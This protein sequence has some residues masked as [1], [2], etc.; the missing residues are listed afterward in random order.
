MEGNNNNNN[1]NNNKGKDKKIRFKYFR[2][3]HR[4]LPENRNL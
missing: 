4:S 3:L 2:N 1:N